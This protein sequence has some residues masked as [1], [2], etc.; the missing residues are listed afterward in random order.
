MNFLQVNVTFYEAVNIIHDVIIRGY[1]YPS[2]AEVVFEGVRSNIDQQIR[3]RKINR[4][5][6]QCWRILKISNSVGRID[7]RRAPPGST[8]INSP[9]RVRYS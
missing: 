1:L 2:T 6:T 7:D 4:I 3:R 5:S 9:N 8:I